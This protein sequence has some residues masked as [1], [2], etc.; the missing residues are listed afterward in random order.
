MKSILAASRCASALALAVLSSC[1]APAARQSTLN[2][3]PPATALTITVTVPAPTATVARP[4]I[5]Q[6]WLTTAYS[7]REKS[8]RAYG[9]LNSMGHSLTQPVEGCR[10]IA[11]D[12]SFLPRGS[13]VMIPGVGRCIVT[14]C[15]SAVKGR[16]ID[17][18]F[19]EIA[20]M[21]SRGSV[22]TDVTVL[23]WGWAP[24][25][26]PGGAVPMLAAQ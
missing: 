1:C 3:V 25:G 20:D 23:R 6:G 17:I 15:G 19:C 7:W 4:G 13:I 18:H 11:A 9:R 14:D 22:T 2:H 26:L 24:A 16:H 5:L 21:N 12:W 10:Q 8:H